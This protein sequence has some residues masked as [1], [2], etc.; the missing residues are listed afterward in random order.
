MEKSYL[1]V[2]QWQLKASLAFGGHQPPLIK[3]HS[4]NRSEKILSK[5]ERLADDPPPSCSELKNFDIIF[6][7]CLYNT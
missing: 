6:Y 2:N 5:I 1:D 7:S 3:K 4:Q